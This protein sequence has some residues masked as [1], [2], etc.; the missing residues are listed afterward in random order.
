MSESPRPSLR[1]TLSLPLLTLYGLGTILGAGIYALIGKVAGEAGANAPTSFLLAGA[2]AL[3]TGLCFAELSARYPVSAGEAVFAKR[4]F[5]SAR[6]ATGVGLM[7]AMSGVVSAATM[8]VA[9][10]GYLNV[11]V[12]VPFSLSVL[13]LTAILVAIA[14]WGIAESVAIAALITLAEVSGLLFVVYVGSSQLL[15]ETLSIHSFVPTWDPTQWGAIV[16]GSFIA[17]YA[18]IGFEDM[19]NV[20]EEV[21]EPEKNMPRGIILALVVSTLFYLVVAIVC[22]NAVAPSDLAR[23]DAPLALVYEQATGNRPVL[24]SAISLLAISNGA[25][26]QCIMAARVLYGLAEQGW[27]PRSLGAIHPRTQTPIRATLG[28]G[29][30]IAAL[31]LAVPLVSL[32]EATSFIILCVFSLVNLALLRIKRREPRTQGFRLPSWVPLLAFVT[33]ALFLA[34]RFVR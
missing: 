10:A 14:C 16:A 28:V 7:I 32:A 12:E 33:T 24:I 4:G 29:A 18:F 5:G 27:L 11:F 30:L 31:A 13:S 34:A 6:L 26:V 1:R 15:P 3:L 25:L 9:F 23:H 2:V 8:A 19:V 20:A 17:F 21:V 22:V